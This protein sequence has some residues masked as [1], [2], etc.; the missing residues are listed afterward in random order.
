MIRRPPRSTRTDTLFPY[1]TLFRSRDPTVNRR[2]AQLV[3]TSHDV[4]VLRRLEREEIWFVEKAS[5]GVSTL[6]SLVVYTTRKDYDFDKQYIEGRYGVVPVRADFLTFADALSESGQ[7]KEQPL[8][9]P[10]HD[11]YA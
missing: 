1:T 3:I 10:A 5:D 8:L 4:A 7:S 9:E 11:T 2:N 6:S